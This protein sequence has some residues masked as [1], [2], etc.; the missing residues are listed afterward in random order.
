MAERRSPSS[1]SSW[2]FVACATLSTPTPSL[3]PPFARRPCVH[4]RNTV[5]IYV[6]NTR[7][8]HDYVPNLVE[9]TVVRASPRPLSRTSQNTFPPLAI[10]GRLPGIFGYSWVSSHL[11]SFHAYRSPECVAARKRQREDAQDVRLVCI[12]CRVSSAVTR[13]W[14]TKSGCAV[15]VSN[16]ST[17]FIVD[18][19]FTSLR[20]THWCRCSAVL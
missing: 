12:T 10:L 9:R 6:L 7:E 16:V 1:L 5:R 18:S 3:F 14:F 17:V 20:F 4:E 11:Q 15:I 13:R 8:R 19:S 2:V